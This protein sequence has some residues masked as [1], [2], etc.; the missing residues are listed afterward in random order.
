MWSLFPQ[1]LKKARWPKYWA[2]YAAFTWCLFLY[3]LIERGAVGFLVARRRPGGTWFIQF[4]SKSVN[5]TP[6]QNS[7]IGVRRGGGSCDNGF[8]YYR[9]NKIKFFNFGRMSFDAA[10]SAPPGSAPCFVVVFSMFP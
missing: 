6:T 4:L 10:P 1:P 5:K 2:S 8:V 7:K 3:L 9:R